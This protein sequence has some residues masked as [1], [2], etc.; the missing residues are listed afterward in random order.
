MITGISI[1]I[2]FRRL[3]TQIE[4][5]K[6]NI[7]LLEENCKKYDEIYDC[8]NYRQVGLSAETQQENAGNSQNAAKRKT[9]AKSAIQNLKT[10]LNN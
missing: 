2:S 5:D 6:K 9:Q 1:S 7:T 3:L 10:M 4:K 8:L